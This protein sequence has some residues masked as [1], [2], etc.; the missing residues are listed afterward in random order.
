MSNFQTDDILNCWHK[1]F[2]QLF[3]DSCSRIEREYVCI[4]KRLPFKALNMGK[5]NDEYFLDASNT[6]IPIGELL[7][8]LNLLVIKQFRDHRDLSLDDKQAPI[9]RSIADIFVESEVA[10]FIVELEVFKDKPFSNLIYIPEFCGRE[11]IKP[12]YF[13]HCFAPERLDK[14]AELTR[15]IGY[16]LESQPSIERYEYLPYIMPSLPESIRYLLPN[17]K[18]TKPKSYRCDA[19]KAALYQYAT[20][21]CDDVIIPR[22]KSILDSLS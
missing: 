20:T 10:H 7:D 9:A 11:N 19:D 1:M 3:G 14:E 12:L 13:I 4:K 6:R 16:W 2:S 8:D 17:K 5:K 15:K 21:F 18:T 22:I